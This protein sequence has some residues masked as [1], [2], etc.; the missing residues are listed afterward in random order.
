MSIG[1]IGYGNKGES[2]SKAIKGH[3]EILVYDVSDEKRQRALS[4]GFGGG[5]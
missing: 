3:A 1:V 5:K 2:F 4:D